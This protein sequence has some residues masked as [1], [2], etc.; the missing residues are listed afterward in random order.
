MKRWISHITGVPASGVRRKKRKSLM[1]NDKEQRRAPRVRDSGVRSAIRT[2]ANVQ[3]VDVSRDG[4]LLQTDKPFEVGSHCTLRLMLGGTP[5]TAAVAIRHVSVISA[6]R[7][8][9]SYRVGAAFLGLTTDSR[10]AIE[11]WVSL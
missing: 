2:R 6:D 1:I 8:S 3:V 7:R 4:V 10:R 5:F 9:C 11:Q